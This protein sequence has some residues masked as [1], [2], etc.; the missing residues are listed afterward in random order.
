MHPWFG[1]RGKLVRG[2]I[3]AL[4][5]VFILLEWITRV[6]AGAIHFLISRLGLTR[7]ERWM[8]G[9]P[10]WCVGPIMFIVAAGYV[11]LELGQFALLAR[12]H[13]TLAGLAHV[14][15][16]LVFPILSYVW[17]LYDER[18]LRYSWIR[19]TYG[20]YVYAHELILGWVHRQEWYSTALGFKHRSVEAARRCFVAARAA[21]GKLSMALSRRNTA[22]DAAR[23]LKRFRFR[24]S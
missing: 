23:R 11:L 6:L 2:L 8:R 5:L 1:R 22:F 24:R 21:F 10:L 3:I 15:K 12:H 19:W 9:L 18:L 7:F 20:M 4:A 16:W 14:L 13:Y 17:R